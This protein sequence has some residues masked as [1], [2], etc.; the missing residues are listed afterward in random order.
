MTMQYGNID[1]LVLLGLISPVPVG[2]WLLFSKSQMGITVA[3]LWAWRIYKE[4]GLKSV[5]FIYLPVALGILISLFVGLRVPNPESLSAWSADIWPFGL[6]IGIPFL[7]VAIKKNDD[8]LALATGLFLVPYV[9]PMSWAAILP[10]AM[11]S[12][13]FIVLGVIFSWIVIIIWRINL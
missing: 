6:F 5:F 12:R 1:W 3:L 8:R 9:G 13:K 4:R 7:L 11:R 2:L 10:L